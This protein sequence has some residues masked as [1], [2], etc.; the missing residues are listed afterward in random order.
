M[1]KLKLITAL[2]IFATLFS[3][4]TD[5]EIVKSE[6]YS[7]IG[8]QT[9][10]PNL[11]ITEKE[12]DWQFKPNGFGI[13]IPFY[14]DGTYKV[15]YKAKVFGG[16]ELDTVFTYFCP[17]ANIAQQVA[18]GSTDFVVNKEEDGFANGSGGYDFE[19]LLSITT[20]APGEN[21]YY[22]P[23]AEV[24]KQTFDVSPTHLK[25]DFNYL[26][27][28]YYTEPFMAIP[29]RT[30]D[31]YTNRAVVRSGKQVVVIEVNPNLLINESNY[32]DNVSTLPINVTITGTDNNFLGTAVVDEGIL[33]GN[34]TAP[35]SNIVVT[36]NFQGRNKFVKIDWECPY[37][38]SL[39]QPY[40]VK[41]HFTVK[42]NGVIVADKIDH[43][44]YTE[45]VRGN[46]QNAT[47]TITTTTGLGESI[48]TTATVVR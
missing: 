9:N 15:E 41:H 23:I 12:F 26:L 34:L 16:T 13:R 18:D 46:Y 2:C 32:D 43:S 44:E 38:E 28:N 45:T 29:A 37:H 1:K 21:G 33:L 36:K 17:I 11:V 8:I 3:C 30:A 20:F 39:E 24:I 40:Y 25:N 47:Y 4:S 31:M 5:E 19:G 6:N 14:A 42:K 35:P 48:P 22:L 7:K 10:T 27:E